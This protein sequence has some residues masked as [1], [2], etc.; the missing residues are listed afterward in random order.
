MAAIF[1]DLNKG[2]IAILDLINMVKLFAWRHGRHIDW[3]KQKE[4]RHIGSY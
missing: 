2:K 4:D 1:I 3:L